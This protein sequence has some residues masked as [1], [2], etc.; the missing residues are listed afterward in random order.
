MTTR[1]NR[2]SYEQ[3]ASMSR[4]RFLTMAG[5]GG[6]LVAGGFLF[7]T[8]LSGDDSS[9]SA[10]AQ[11]DSA[12]DATVNSDGTTA[13]SVETSSGTTKAQ[14]QGHGNQS[15]TL[16]HLNVTWIGQAP[17]LPTGC[18]ITAATMM[19][20][21]YGYGASKLELDSFLEQTDSTAT[22]W[23]GGQKVGYDPD[24][25]FIGNT[26][27]ENGWYCT[28]TPVVAALNEYLSAYGITDE[29]ATDITGTSAEELY[30]YIDDGDPV[31]VWVTIGLN[32]YYVSESWISETDGEEVNV[33][34]VDHAMTLIGYDEDN[35][36]LAD[37]LDAI[38][39]Y[40]KRLFES[41][42]KSRGC[43]AVV[44]R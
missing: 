17:E 9:N 40:R 20:D 3:N 11:T 33:S 24:D 15:G 4:R 19:I 26:S 2:T 14:M 42:Y 35:V 23:E 29:K 34:V 44:M 1:Y 18:E 37:P 13:A 41:A 27:T 43:M 39:T 31:T 30:T 12:S 28:P 22:W 6:S 10:L 21:Y 16:S 5:V 25:A 36:V 38:V 32:D 7:H 8:L